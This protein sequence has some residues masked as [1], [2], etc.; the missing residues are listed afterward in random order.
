MTPPQRLSGPDPAY[1]AQ[2]LEQEVE[3]TMAVR[4]IVT[5][6]G[7]VHGCRVLKSLPY[8]DAAAIHALEQRRYTPALIN[9]QPVAVDYLFRIELRLPAP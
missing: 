9:G 8:M 7:I 2:A 4:C 6:Q 3:G 5:E 1:T